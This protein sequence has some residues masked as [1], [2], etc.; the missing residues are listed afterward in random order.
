MYNQQKME[1]IKEGAYFDYFKF[2]SI[3]AAETIRKLEATIQEELSEDVFFDANNMF[4]R[5]KTLL[6][7]Y[8]LLIL[9]IPSLIFRN[10]RFL[11]ICGDT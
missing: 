6:S 11:L 4:K 2:F 9:G 10:Q 3:N 8:E 5:I 7:S 1:S